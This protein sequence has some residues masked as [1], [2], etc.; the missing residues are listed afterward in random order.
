MLTIIALVSLVVNMITAIRLRHADTIPDWKN[1]LIVFGMG[2]SWYIA[3][4]AFK[5]DH[6]LS[7]FAWIFIG[8]LNN[9]RIKMGTPA[10][11]I[12]IGWFPR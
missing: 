2:F 6:F 7:M 10:V 3:L 8:L 5:A 11:T 4:D 12:P 1:I 9:M